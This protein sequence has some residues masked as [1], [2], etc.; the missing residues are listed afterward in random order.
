MT[1][2]EFKAPFRKD[3]NEFDNVESYVTYL[4]KQ[5]DFFKSLAKALFEELDLYKEEKK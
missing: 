5:L 3:R 1:T 2:E 4:E